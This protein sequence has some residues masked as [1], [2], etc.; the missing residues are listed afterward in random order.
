M[1]RSSVRWGITLIAAVVAVT[2]VDAQ[3][4]RGIPRFKEEVNVTPEMKNRPGAMD[5]H[6]LTFSSPFALPNVGLA[7]GD[8]VF[9]TSPSR[10]IQV[11]SADRSMAY[12]WL[13]TMPVSRESST[14]TYEVWFGEPLAVDAPRPLIAWF[15]P[16]QSS[17]YEFVYAKAPRRLALTSPSGFPDPATI[18]ANRTW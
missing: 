18:L 17:G 6:Y 7:P 5:D 10:T 9:R 13:N 14:D 16:D 8:Y 15:L 12:A 2:T 4:Q 1:T 11:L 3:R